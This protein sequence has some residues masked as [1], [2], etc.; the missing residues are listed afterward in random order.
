MFGTHRSYSPLFR[1]WWPLSHP[2]SRSLR[3]RQPQ[4]RDVRMEG[5]HLA[6]AAVGLVEDVP[7]AWQGDRMRVAV[8]AH[9]AQGAEIVVEGPVFLHQHHDMLHVPD[10]P[11]P[12][13]AL[14]GGRP[15]DARGEQRCSCRSGTELKKPAAA[16]CW[17]SRVSSRRPVRADSLVAA[18]SRTA[19]I[20]GTRREQ[21]AYIRISL[22]LGRSSTF[23]LAGNVP[24]CCI[25]VAHTAKGYVSGG[26]PRSQWAVRSSGSTARVSSMW[27]TASNWLDSLAR[28]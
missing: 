17:H 21:P 20:R 26:S 24:L 23:L 27:M 7:P 25:W 16:D 1:T 13:V 6:G 2:W 22:Q 19:I 18:R 12:M 3:E 8:A 10:R 4:V 9:P 14:D 28:K 15:G 11:G 5:Q